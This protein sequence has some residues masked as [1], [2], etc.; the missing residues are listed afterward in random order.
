MEEKICLE[1]LNPTPRG[2]KYLPTWKKRLIIAGVICLFAIVLIIIIA[3]A[4][5]SSNLEKIGEINCIYEIEITSK[6]VQIIS[7]DYSKSSK[8]D[9]IIDSKKINFAKE[10]QFKETGEHHIHFS[11]RNKAFKRSRQT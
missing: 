8:F 2:F 11:R 1:D 3:V 5:N 6:K 10:Y 4:V 7:K 9:I